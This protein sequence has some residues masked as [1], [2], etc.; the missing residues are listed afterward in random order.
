ML[1][2]RAPG[3]CATRA[4]VVAIAAVTA[5]LASSC[6]SPEEPPEVTRF[7]SEVVV[8]EIVD[9]PENADTAEPVW[10]DGVPG[11]NGPEGGGAHGGLDVGPTGDGSGAMSPNGKM[12]SYCVIGGYTYSGGA[13]Y[14]DGT[15]MNNDPV[16]DRLRDEFYAANPWV[17]PGGQGATYDPSRCP[18]GEAV[19]AYDPDLWGGGTGMPNPI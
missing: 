17:C 13:I 4:A 11:V 2:T 1:N 3:P 14:T 19:S 12:I 9:A 8:T 5:V 16:C 15:S 7:V 10:A 6:S 18:G